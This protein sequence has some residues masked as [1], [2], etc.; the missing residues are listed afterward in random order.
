MGPR[1][2]FW[3]THLLPLPAY[4]FVR[5]L[6]CGPIQLTGLHSV[7]STGWGIIFAVACVLPRPLPLQFKGEQLK[8]GSTSFFLLPPNNECNKVL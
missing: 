8:G 7:R 6:Q 3:G 2:E 1:A 5:Q 4:E